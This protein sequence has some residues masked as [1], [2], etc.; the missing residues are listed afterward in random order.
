MVIA[1]AVFTHIGAMPWRA[2]GV[3]VVGS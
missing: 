1:G 2:A 3:I